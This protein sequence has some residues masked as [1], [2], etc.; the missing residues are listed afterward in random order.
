MPPCQVAASCCAHLLRNPLHAAGPHA[1]LNGDLAR[2][3]RGLQQSV[4][5]GA[6]RALSCGKRV[7]RIVV[8]IR[9]G[10][11]LA[12]LR[13]GATFVDGRS[14]LSR[15]DD[16]EPPVETWMLLIT[17]AAAIVS[18]AL[19][20]AIIY[21]ASGRSSHA[22]HLQEGRDFYVPQSG[23]YRGRRHEPRRLEAV[24]PG[25]AAT[26]VA[27]FHRGPWPIQN[28]FNHQPARHDLPPAVLRDEGHV[29]PSERDFDKSLQI[30]QPC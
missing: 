8:W 3:Y 12:S 20:L 13:C 16:A 27:L 29:A 17:A 5:L 6:P 23:Y 4:S 1:E 10:W 18:V 24:I 19:V 11:R 2:A 15:D 21:A 28:G 22:R 7:A 30:C 25:T 14:M 9:S 26:Q